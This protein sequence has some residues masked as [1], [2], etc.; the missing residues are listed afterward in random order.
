MPRAG[1]PRQLYYFFHTKLDFFSFFKGACHGKHAP[2]V[3]CDLSSYKFA[4]QTV[5]WDFCRVYD[6]PVLKMHLSVTKKKF[7]LEHQVRA[8]QKV[9]YISQV[10]SAIFPFR[11]S[12]QRRTWI[13]TKDVLCGKFQRYIRRRQ[14]K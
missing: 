14:R 2:E 3:Q 7:T 6:V 5:I 4:L 8:E 10:S 9:G 1:S 13:I 12:Q 11:F